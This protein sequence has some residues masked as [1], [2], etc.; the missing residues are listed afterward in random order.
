MPS[1]DELDWIIRLDRRSARL[2]DR[3][4]TLVAAMGRQ[5]LDADLDTDLETFY[6]TKC[7]D[8]HI[9]GLEKHE[10]EEAMAKVNVGAGGHKE[11]LAKEVGEN[12]GFFWKSAASTS[13]RPL[14]GPSQQPPASGQAGS[15]DSSMGGLNPAATAD[16]SGFKSG[17]G[18]AA[19]SP[20]DGMS[21]TTGPGDHSGRINSTALNISASMPQSSKVPPEGSTS[22]ASHS[23]SGLSNI[24]HAPIYE[25]IQED[26]A[27][28]E[29][30]AHEGRS[31]S[32]G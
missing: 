5:A 25:I 15:S 30:V 1:C 31:R 18:R 29:G 13:T 3:H 9:H 4:F 28:A 26:Q 6:V 21:H 2:L 11:G 19:E 17:D 23:S 24:K 10:G 27:R 20:E 7:L 16:S 14:G 22:L 12:F 32:R 8:D